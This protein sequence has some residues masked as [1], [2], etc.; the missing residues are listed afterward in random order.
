ML[1]PQAFRG[2]AQQVAVAPAVTLTLGG[3]PATRLRHASGLF[4]LMRDLGGA[5]SIAA[6][7]TILIDRT[8]LHLL[9]LAEHLAA[10]KPP[11]FRSCRS[12]PARYCQ[13]RGDT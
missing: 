5:T 7:G 3:L 9:R 10:A 6:C 8:N 13:L 1:L 12:P 4:N 2:L 11:W